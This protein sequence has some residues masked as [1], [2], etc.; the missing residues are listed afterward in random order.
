MTAEHI[1]F[2]SKHGRGLFVS[3]EPGRAD[4]LRLVDGVPDNDWSPRSRSASIT[5]TEAFAHRLHCDHACCA[6]RDQQRE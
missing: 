1:N 6:S 3:P 2:V 5:S 4:A